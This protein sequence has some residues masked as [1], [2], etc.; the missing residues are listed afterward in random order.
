MLVLVVVLTM[1]HAASAHP[2]VGPM[3]PMLSEDEDAAALDFSP[4]SEAEEDAP[5]AVLSYG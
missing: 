3:A 2:V 5:A 4:L 1:E